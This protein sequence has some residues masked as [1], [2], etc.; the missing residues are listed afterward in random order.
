MS[1]VP[2]QVALELIAYAK[3]VEISANYWD[4][5]STSAFEFARLMSSPK[6]KKANPKFEVNFKIHDD[7]EEGHVYAEFTDNEIWETKTSDYNA[8][9]LKA[10]FFRYT[11]MAEITAEIAS[12]DVVA[13]DD[14]M[15]MRG[16]G[17]K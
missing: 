12:A 10:E 4:P 6:L 17:Q 14:L 16:K 11:K 8:T 1:R 9:E 5:L 2:K 7:D 13:G 15:M 3:K